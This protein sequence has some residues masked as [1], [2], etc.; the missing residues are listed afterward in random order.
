MKFLVSYNKTACLIWNLFHLT[1]FRSSL[2]IFLV[3][4][5]YPS[6]LHFNHVVYSKSLAACVVLSCFIQCCLVI[7][8]FYVQPSVIGQNFRRTKRQQAGETSNWSIE[9]KHPF[10]GTLFSGGLIRKLVPH[11]ILTQC[12]PIFLYMM[13]GDL[14][15]L[16]SNQYAV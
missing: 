4:S 12:F 15:I 13:S 1:L 11:L 10:K 3:F 14:H 9:D 6:H 5:L 8:C 7:C 16:S 2:W